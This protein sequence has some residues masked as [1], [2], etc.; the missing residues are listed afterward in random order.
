VATKT[1]AWIEDDT[2]FIDPVVKPLEDAGYD[3]IRIRSYR[4]AREAKEQ[5][6]AADLI[7][8]DMILP[9]GNGNQGQGASVSS[10]MP[11]GGQLLQ[12]LR[13]Q[14]IN[15][16]VVVLSVKRDQ[17]LASAL[18]ALGTVPVILRKPVLPSILKE[19]IE[20]VLRR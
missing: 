18:Q 8:L 17:Q 3:F 14:G 19:R 11:L 5:I 12:F 20:D 15:T 13:E 7:L 1:I 6:R 4:E 9:S 2:D 10:E 16:P